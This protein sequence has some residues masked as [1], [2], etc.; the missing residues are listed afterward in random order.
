M[1]D[2]FTFLFYFLLFFAPLW[3]VS[4]LIIYFSKRTLTRK[5]LFAKAGILGLY[6]FTWLL[7]FAGWSDNSS[8]HD[9]AIDPSWGGYTPL[10][11]EHALSLLVFMALS[12]FANYELWRKG[13][14]FPPLRLVIYMA[15]SLMGIV[16]SIIMLMQFSHH[17]D[18]GHYVDT[19][20][21][22]LMMIAPIVHMGFSVFYL[23]KVIS[24]EG[25]KASERTYK[26]AFLRKLNDRIARF[27]KLP[28]VSV[29][30]VFPLFFIIT[31]ILILLGQ[32]Y[33]SLS[34]VFTETT[35]W[36]FSEKTHPPYLDQ[37]GHYLCTVAACGSPNVVKPLRLG[38][39]HGE[40]IIVN[41]QLLVANAFEDLISKKYPKL[42]RWIRRS[43]DTYGY[44]LSKDIN[45]VKKSNLTYRLMKP[46]EWVFL[47]YIYLNSERPEKLIAAQYKL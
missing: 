38:K 14:R 18:E 7:F 6:I 20:F 26:N 8:P 17:E 24:A 3:G 32:E 25:I 40:E 22:S 43:Y 44:P 5:Q 23:Y 46:F 19:M 29:L 28:L 10:S 42:H 30:M 12:I 27:G 34:Q 4:L 13:N 47:V 21:G 37:N 33:D 16:L 31:L 35:T 15:L 39:R 45:T 9:L 11:G 36:R 41:R 2:F 1:E